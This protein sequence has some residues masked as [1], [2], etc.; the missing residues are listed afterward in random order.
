[1][2]ISTRAARAAAA[3]VIAG[4]ALATIVGPVSA[5]SPKPVV[6]VSTITFNDP[7]PNTGD[8]TVDGGGGLMCQHG[9]V[10]DTRYVFA[11]YQSNRRIQIL[12]DKDF[13]C[14][15]GSGTIFVKI[16]VHIDNGLERFS[17]IVQGGTGPY[18]HLHG[19]GQG[20][21]VPWSD[22]DANGNINTYSGFLVG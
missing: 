16:Q 2:A 1:M 18:S 20:S 14:D 9:S 21:T 12:V 17:W 11:G 4:L 5:A 6:I 19:S 8:F 7:G 15:D 10:V 3:A 22:A 13:I